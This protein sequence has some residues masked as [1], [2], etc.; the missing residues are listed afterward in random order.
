MTD[1]LHRHYL[2]ELFSTSK[3]G[4][5][6]ASCIL[7]T[8]CFA[9]K[10]TAA[11]PELY[12]PIHGQF[13]GIDTASSVGLDC[14]ECR[15]ALDLARNGDLVEAR[16]LLANYISE[17]ANDETSL[18]VRKI[19]EARLTLGAIYW[20]SDDFDNSIYQYKRA[21]QLC[22]E[23]WEHL[24]H[25]WQ[26]YKSAGQQKAASRIHKIGMQRSPIIFGKSYSQ[27]GGL[28]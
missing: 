2:L 11:L 7:W 19:Y 16:V 8:G 3:I 6:V 22:P 28:I 5:L 20:T 14:S 26:T 9:V 1:Q 13:I 23:R 21:G 12:N 15:A 10:D 24:F 17:V 18:E 4:I 25:L 27:N